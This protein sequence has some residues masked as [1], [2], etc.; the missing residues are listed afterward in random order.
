MAGQHRAA[1]RLRNIAHQQARPAVDRRHHLGEPFEKGDQ[2][3]IAPVAVAG[4]PHHLPRLPVDRQRLGAREAASGIKTDGARLKF[5]R[6]QH[7]PEDL[8]GRQMRIRRIGQ[9]GQGFRVER[10]L[11]LGQRRHRGEADENREDRETSARHGSFLVRPTDGSTRGVR[12]KPHA[13]AK[14]L[15]LLTTLS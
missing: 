3:R 1:P 14:P 13:A 4:Q 15:K 10:P 9:R 5:G 11:V 2:H 12:P 7:P 8:F 6:R